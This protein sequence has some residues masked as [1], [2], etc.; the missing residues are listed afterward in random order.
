MIQLC[1]ASMAFSGKLDVEA[2]WRVIRK[3]V[4]EILAA[5][6]EFLWCQLVSGRESQNKDDTYQCGQLKC[7]HPRMCTLFKVHIQKIMNI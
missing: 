6:H 4:T 7:L 2:V 1:S 3:N 5:D